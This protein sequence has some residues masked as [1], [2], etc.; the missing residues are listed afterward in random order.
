MT[1]VVAALDRIA[2]DVSITAP[3][4]WTAATADEHLEIRD[5]FLLEVV[6]DITDRVD[7]P[8]PIS[9]IQSITGTDAETYSLNATFKRVARHDWAV[10]EST[11]T[12]RPVTPATNDS[13]YTRIQDE[14]LGG[15]DR[16]YKITGYEGNYSIS[17]EPAPSAAVTIKVHYIND[18]WMISSGGTKGSTLSAVTDILLLPRRLVEVGVITRWR[19]RKGLPF[20][21]KAREYEVL[22]NRYQ[23]ENRQLR[24]ISFGDQRTWT[25]W[26]IP[27]P[28]SIPAGS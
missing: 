2:R 26:D 9:A 25:P 16:F 4:D 5:D 15:A 11:N 21:D 6:D 19:E 12:T 24:K 18:Y 7:W 20:S 10:Y 23:N 14:S 3:S 17:F 13:D 27:V 22:L 1:T 28:S 8:D